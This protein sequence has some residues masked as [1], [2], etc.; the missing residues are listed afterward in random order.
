MIIKLGR[1]FT[2][3]VVPITIRLLVRHLCLVPRSLA[4]RE[5]ERE[6]ESLNP[7]DELLSAHLLNHR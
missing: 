6:R 1:D 5:R 7:W 3:M 2:L 4:S